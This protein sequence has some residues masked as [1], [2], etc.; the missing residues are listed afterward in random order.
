MEEA[1]MA[2]ADELG[3]DVETETYLLWIVEE[4]CQLGIG[5]VPADR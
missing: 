3:V 4:V 2:I 5:Y 1:I